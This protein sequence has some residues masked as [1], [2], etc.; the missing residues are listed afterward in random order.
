MRRSKKKGRKASLP[1]VGSRSKTTQ[2]EE[3]AKLLKIKDLRLRLKTNVYIPPGDL[4]KLCS[5]NSRKGVP[6]YLFSGVQL[7][8][9]LSSGYTE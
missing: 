1:K 2:S 6:R 5:S 8:A 7:P 4:K 9:L 3:A